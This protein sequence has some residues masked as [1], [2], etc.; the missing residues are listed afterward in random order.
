MSS[1]T[2]ISPETVEPKGR[3]VGGTEHSW[4]RAVPGGTGIAVLAILTSKL[5]R[6]SG[7]ENALHKLQNSHPIL[8]SRL[9]S[10]SNTNTFSFITSLTPFIK[11]KAFNLSSTFKILENPLKPKNQ[12]LSPLHLVLEHELNQNSWYNHNKAPSFINDI[13]DMFFATTYALPNEKWVLVLRLHAS[14]CDRTTAVSLLQELVVLVSE[15]E[16]G[17][18]QKEIAN[19]EEVTSS[20]EDLVPNKKAKK[21]LW[22]RGIDM[23][24]YSVNSLRL[25]NLKFKDSKSPR[26]SQVVRLQMN[27][28]DTEKIIAGCRSRGIKLCG[29][30]ASAGLIAAHKSK[31]RVDKQRKYAVVTLTDCRSVLDP[32]LSNH[33]F[34]FYHSAILNAHVM[35]GGEKLWELAQKTYA[36]FASYKNCN[37]HFSDMADLNFLMCKAIDNPGLTPSSSLRTALVSVFEDSVVDDH[38]ALQKEVGVEDYMGCAS[39]HGIGP[40]IAIFD[41]IRDGRLDCVCVY[42]S[43]LHSREQMQEFIDS[44]KSVLVEGCNHV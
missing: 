9:H 20:I 8:R 2:L 7:L 17:A 11:L 12:S 38:A 34:G 16:K 19:E 31:S 32:T 28:K 33:H 40:S 4:C 44:M 36:A 6:N 18:L 3:A 39:A 10:G 26:S 42:P 29:A 35:K 25:T 15:E 41:T 37:R 5:P 14:A 43:P 27:Q 30:L 21:G 13:Q 24:G 23:L 22:E 1:Q